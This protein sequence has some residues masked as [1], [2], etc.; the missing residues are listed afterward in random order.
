MWRINLTKKHVA[1][2]SGSVYICFFRIFVGEKYIMIFALHP[3]IEI[4]HCILLSLVS[5]GWNFQLFG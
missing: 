2:A 4:I 3:T 1:L 5:I